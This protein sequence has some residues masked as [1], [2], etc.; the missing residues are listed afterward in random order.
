ML[1]NITWIQ[2]TVKSTQ[3]DRETNTLSFHLASFYKMSA[4]GRKF[5]KVSF[6]KP[7]VKLIIICPYNLMHCATWVLSCLSLL[8]MEERS[9]YLYCS[10]FYETANERDHCLILCSVRLL[11]PSDLQEFLYPQLRNRKKL[12]P[13][14]QLP[15]AAKKTNQFL[16]MQ[17]YGI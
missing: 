14:Q 4:L 12:V 3:A 10:R 11:N 9:N 15:G 13:W 16:P 5:N 6:G 7:T 17:G 1:K 2:C 8:F